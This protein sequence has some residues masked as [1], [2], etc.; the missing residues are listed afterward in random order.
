VALVDVQPQKQLGK[1]SI[2][3]AKNMNINRNAKS[4]RTDEQIVLHVFFADCSLKWPTTE[5]P[6][7]VAWE[8]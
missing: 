3:L 8:G 4:G 6:S 5:I 1:G 2:A 7:A